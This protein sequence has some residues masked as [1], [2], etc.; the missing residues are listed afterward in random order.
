[1]IHLLTLKNLKLV[2]LNSII[3]ALTA[4]LLILILILILFN[5]LPLGLD[6]SFNVCTLYLNCLLTVPFI[7]M[8]GSVEEDDPFGLK[9]CH[10]VELLDPVQV[11]H[12]QED[13]VSLT[14]SLT[15]IKQ[16]GI[17]ESDTADLLDFYIENTALL[18]G[19]Q[20]FTSRHLCIATL[21]N[22]ENYV[23]LSDIK[24][25]Q[26]AAPQ[27]V[28]QQD[29]VDLTSSDPFILKAFHTLFLVDNT[30]TP[31]TYWQLI[32]HNYKLFGDCDE[33]DFEDINQEVPWV[34]VRV[35]AHYLKEFGNEP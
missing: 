1:M 20:L 33:F 19:Q 12:P 15:P 22:E 35:K 3:A 2:S 25:L 6:Y 18:T 28:S 17:I 5:L 26:V 30:W 27:A 9:N 11:E 10:Y 34:L 7:S 8:G 13:T 4:L 32:L 16:I 14:E 29:A 31:N 21:L 24:Y 23:E